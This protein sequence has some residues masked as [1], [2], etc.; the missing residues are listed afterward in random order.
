M[1][2]LSNL[3]DHEDNSFD[4]E[5]LCEMI[6]AYVPEFAQVDRYEA[7]SRLSVTSVCFTSSDTDVYSNSVEVGHD[8]NRCTLAIINIRT[9]NPYIRTRNPGQ[10]AESAKT[11]YDLWCSLIFIP[12]CKSDDQPPPTLINSMMHYSKTFKFYNNIFMQHCCV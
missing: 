1:E 3:K 10:P 2:V 6:A 8:F 12:F 5:E 7:Y 11:V 9:R 4:V